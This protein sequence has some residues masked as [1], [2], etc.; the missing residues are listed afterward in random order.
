ME[1]MKLQLDQNVS[2][3]GEQKYVLP[4]LRASDIGVLSSVVE[5]FPLAL[6]EYGIAGLPAIATNVGQCAEV[7]DHGRAGILVPAESTDR[8]AAALLLLLRSPEQRSAFGRNFNRRVQ[9]MYGPS[10]MTEQISQ[11]YESVLKGRQR[12]HAERVLTD[13]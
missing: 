11:V 9:E 1:I 7:L 13:S 6:L 5:G 4:I 12:D 10:S 8:L 3:L 2:V